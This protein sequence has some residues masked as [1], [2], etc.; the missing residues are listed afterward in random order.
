MH[1]SF[2]RN[3]EERKTLFILIVHHL[4]VDNEHTEF[5]TNPSGGIKK[6]TLTFVAKFFWLMVR[7]KFSHT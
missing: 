5:V 7:N 1:Q 4:N 2:Y 6:V 3:E